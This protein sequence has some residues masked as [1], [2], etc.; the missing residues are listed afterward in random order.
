M[1]WRAKVVT[2]NLDMMPY[3][4]LLP[5]T[6]LM[7]THH[8]SLI[9]NYKPRFRISIVLLLKLP[10]TLRPKG[11]YYFIIAVLIIGAF[12]IKSHL[13]TTHRAVVNGSHSKG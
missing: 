11:K 9:L 13:H 4:Y 2:C 6:S 1:V 10:A 5:F 12:Y 7:P 8:I 3:S